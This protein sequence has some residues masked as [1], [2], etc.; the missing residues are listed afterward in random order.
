MK[1]VP[2]G[3]DILRFRVYDDACTTKELVLQTG[4]GASWVQKLAVKMVAA[5]LWERCYKRVGSELKPAYRRTK[6]GHE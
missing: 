1:E 5:G 2:L 6:K 4:Y 3:E